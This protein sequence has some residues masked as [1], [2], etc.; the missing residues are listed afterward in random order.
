MSRQYLLFAKLLSEY[1]ARNP[2]LADDIAYSD[3]GYYYLCAAL[4]SVARR[5]SAT[6]R[7]RGVDLAALEQKV[8]ALVV[9]PAEYIG[10]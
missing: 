7:L 9:K 10:Q 4:H 1:G 8:N 2:S 5:K 3:P 6:R